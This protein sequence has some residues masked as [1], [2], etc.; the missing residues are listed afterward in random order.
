LLSVLGAS[1]LFACLISV[2]NAILQ[3]YNAERKPI[4]SMGVGA[5]VKIA[6]DYILMGIKQINVFGAPVSTFLC[7]AAVVILNFYFIKK[8][9]CGLE[10][11]T[12]LFYRPLA[13]AVVSIGLAFGLYTAILHFLGASRIYTVMCI[14]IAA[15]LYLFAAMKLKAVDEDDIKMLPKGERIY[16]ILNRMRLI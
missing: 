5:V 13:A 11:V 3:A 12:K 16:S 10:G 14:G 8:Y 6:A 4:I 15:V 7:N 1:V 9:A 2:T